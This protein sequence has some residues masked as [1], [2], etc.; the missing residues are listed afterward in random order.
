[1]TIRKKK[2]KEA[3]HSREKEQEMIYW[4]HKKSK[5]YA[6]NMIGGKIGEKI[7]LMPHSQAK[8]I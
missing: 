3:W 6:I 4:K 5:N 2:K 1:M 7:K 8:E